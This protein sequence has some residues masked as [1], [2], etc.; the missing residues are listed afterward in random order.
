MTSNLISYKYGYVENV[1]SPHDYQNIDYMDT[2]VPLWSELYKI[3]LESPSRD[4]QINIALCAAII[5]LGKCNRYYHDKRYEFEEYIKREI[6]RLNVEI[7]ELILYIDNVIA[8]N[9][10]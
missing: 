6:Q 8:N 1:K 10:N 4:I 5:Q 9:S 3:N 7:D 2:I